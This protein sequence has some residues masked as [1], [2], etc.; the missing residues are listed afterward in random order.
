MK[1][2]IDTKEDSSEE[3]KKVI[4]L[5]QHLVGN[6]SFSNVSNTDIFSNNSNEI[7]NSSET[8]NPSET[9]NSSGG[10]FNMFG[11]KTDQDTQ[12]STTNSEPTTTSILEESDNIEEKPKKA[13]VI[14]Y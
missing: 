5:L 3:I 12:Q 6:E 7:E 14:T 9:E 11:G 1:I 8:D 4:K 2:T 13:R 10:L